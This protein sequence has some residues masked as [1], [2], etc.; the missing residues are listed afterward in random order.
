MTERTKQKQAVVANLAD[1]GCD[2]E[3]IE[4]FMDFLKS[5][6]KEAGLSLLANLRACRDSGLLQE[7]RH[8]LLRLHGAVRQV[9]YRPPLPEGSD[10]ARCCGPVP[11]QLEELIEK[12]GRSAAN[13][14]SLPCRSLPT[15]SLPKEQCGVDF[16]DVY[17][18]HWL[19]QANYAIA[20]KFDEFVFLM[21]CLRAELPS[22]NFHYTM[23]YK[24][25]KSPGINS[26]ME[27]PT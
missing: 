19:N 21:S 7:K 14:M 22:A 4:Q 26:K 6:R 17:L 16:L 9:R 15:G 24:S 25:C 27:E 18:L 20:E 5:G 1:A 13:M 8:Y 10:R 11:T 3:Q 12:C 2:K 23:A